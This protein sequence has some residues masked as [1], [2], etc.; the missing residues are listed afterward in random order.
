MPENTYNENNPPFS[1]N[2]K[3]P[4]EYTNDDINELI[5]AYNESGD[6]SARLFTAALIGHA[7][8][9]HGMMTLHIR[10]GEPEN[11]FPGANNSLLAEY[12]SVR[13]VLKQGIEANPPWYDEKEGYDI[14][15]VED[16]F[17]VLADDCQSL[18]PK[19]PSIH[20]KNPPF[21]DEWNALMNAHAVDP[22]T[23]KEIWHRRRINFEELYEKVKNMK[24]A[25]ED[26]N[27]RYR[28]HDRTE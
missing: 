5:R 28:W 7:D 12:N 26:P 16:A 14:G 22:Q 21:H 24:I 20:P 8:G 1:F 27:A 23:L 18:D 13:E 9:P 10:R 15:P 4:N 6:D 19:V 2:Q 11:S 25:P 3:Y 17:F